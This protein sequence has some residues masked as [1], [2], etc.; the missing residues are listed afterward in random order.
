MMIAM[1]TFNIHLFPFLHFRCPAKDAS[2][3]MGVRCYLD[4]YP[5]NSSICECANDGD[6]NN[7]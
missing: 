4:E 1:L 2:K 7:A 3:V 5:Y 6:D